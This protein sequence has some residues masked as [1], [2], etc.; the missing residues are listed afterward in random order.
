MLFIHDLII[1]DDSYSKLLNFNDI[2]I[3]KSYKGKYCKNE[4]SLIIDNKIS[5]QTKRSI[6]ILKFGFICL[7]NF[8]SG[9]S[10]LN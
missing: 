6:L 7:D 1:V 5:L 3:Y 4:F 10:D 2:C 9:L 8:K